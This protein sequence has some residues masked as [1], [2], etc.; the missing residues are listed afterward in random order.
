MYAQRIITYKTPFVYFA[1]IAGIESG[2]YALTQLAKPFIP[3][4]LA[5]KSNNL[6]NKSIIPKA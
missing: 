5:T 4:L 3:M 6:K 2:K 1:I